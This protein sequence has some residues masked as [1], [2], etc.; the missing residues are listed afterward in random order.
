[1]ASNFK[2]IVHSNSDNVHLKLS[3]DFD[4]SSA[5]ELLDCM[6]KN[7]HNC[8]NVFIH[9]AC[10]KRIVPFGQNVFRLNLGNLKKNY[11]SFVFTGEKASFFKNT[12][13][14]YLEDEQ[15]YLKEIA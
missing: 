15:D 8:N 10:L 13:P 3:G 11:E 9:T 6:K 14:N 1:M 5:C 7:C 2:I 12:W 4:G